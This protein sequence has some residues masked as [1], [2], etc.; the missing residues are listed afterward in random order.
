MLGKLS[1]HFICVALGEGVVRLFSL[2]I[3]CVGNLL[4]L[5]LW[6]WGLL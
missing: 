4:L 3:G 1:D 2:L 6:H 5:A